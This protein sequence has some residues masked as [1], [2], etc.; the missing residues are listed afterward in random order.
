MDKLAKQ[1]LNFK[2]LMND[3]I[4]YLGSEDDKE[5]DLLYSTTFELTMSRKDGRHQEISFDMGPEIWEQIELFTRDYVE[6]IIDYYGTFSESPELEKELKIA[7]G[8]KFIETETDYNQASDITYIFDVE[9][10]KGEMVSRTLK[11]FYYGLPN[12]T[13]TQIFDG[14]LKATF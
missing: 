3:T 13:Q 8:L 1:L 4:E 9:Y 12:K 7:Y 6:T 2:A 11:G 10:D 5:T 14:K